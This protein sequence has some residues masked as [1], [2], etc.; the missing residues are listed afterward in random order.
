MSCIIARC[1]T[2]AFTYLCHV[3]IVIVWQ[4][5]EHLH[6]RGFHELQSESADAS[7][8]AGKQALTWLLI[9]NM[10]TE[11]HYVCIFEG[12]EQLLNYLVFN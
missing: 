1:D 3:H 2:A 7:T 5:V 11:I 9:G 6:H 10:E 4:G 8:P 12:F